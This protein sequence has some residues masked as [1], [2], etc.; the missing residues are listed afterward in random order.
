MLPSAI[1]VRNPVL[2]LTFSETV[3]SCLSNLS[4]ASSASSLFQG[5]LIHE[6]WHLHYVG[7]LR[8]RDL[9]SALHLFHLLFVP[10]QKNRLKRDLYKKKVKGK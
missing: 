1:Q 6:F 2:E 5:N 10:S 4:S 7:A 3:S 8:G 9:F